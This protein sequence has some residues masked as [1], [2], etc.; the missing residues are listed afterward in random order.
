MGLWGKVTC[1]A[2]HQSIPWHGSCRT[3]ASTFSVVLCL[4]V[5]PPTH[6][7]TRTLNALGI[8]PSSSLG[9]FVPDPLVSK[10]SY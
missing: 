5:S 3:P 7:H 1:E 2:F 4:S 9:V 8:I 10:G 6:T